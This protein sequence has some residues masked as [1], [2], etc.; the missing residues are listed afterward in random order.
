LN[1]IAAIIGTTVGIAFGVQ[2]AQAHV[3]LDPVA[4]GHLAQRRR[5]RPADR[6]HALRAARPHGLVGAH[7]RKQSV[8]HLSLLRWRVN[9]LDLFA[10]PGGWDVALKRMGLDPLGVEWDDAACA[11][12]EAAGLRTLQ[13]NVAELD[14][15]GSVTSTCSSPRRPARRGRWPASAW[16]RRTS[17]TSS[18]APTSWRWA[19]TPATS[20]AEQCEDNRSMLVVE[21][22]RF[23]RHLKP[24]YVALEQ[25]PPVLEL[26]TLFAT[27]LEQWGYSV[28]TGVLEAER[29]GVP[30]TRE[31]AILIASLNGPVAPPQPT[32]Q[33]YIPGEPQRHDIT[34]DGEVL[35]WVSMAEALGW[36]REVSWPGIRETNSGLR[37]PNLPGLHRHRS[38]GPEVLA[39]LKDR[40]RPPLR[41]VVQGLRQPR[42]KC[43]PRSAAQSRLKRYLPARRSA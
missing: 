33:R 28:W 34:F 25:V 38:Q 37:R 26:W 36:L 15:A 24:T 31:R 11:T 29:Y 43:A 22:I 27:F 21:P 2:D 35:P 4:S 41:C 14:P 1:R 13:G 30:Q 8:E 19:T 10:G 16:A 12:R 23:I 18:P 3:R 32:H 17:S 42:R 5:L 6:A 7:R 39:R 40:Q 20:T 9:V